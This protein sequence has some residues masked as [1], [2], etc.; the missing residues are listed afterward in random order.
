MGAAAANPQAQ[1]RL[2]RQESSATAALTGSLHDPDGRPVVGANIALTER[3]TGRMSAT[4]NSGDGVFRLLEVAP[5]TYDL[6]VTAAGYETIERAALELEPDKTVTLELV[7]RPIIIA[8]DLTS[9][10]PRAPELGPPSASVEETPGTPYSTIQPRAGTLPVLGEP[11]T[12]PSASQ[13]FLETPERWSISIPEWNRYARSGEY[14]YVRP[15]WWD[16]FNRNK[17]KG[18]VPILGQQTFLNFTGTSV[19]Q[20]DGRRLPLPSGVSTANPGSPGFFGKGEQLFLG[21]TFRFSFDLFHGDTSFRPVDW[22]IRV[23]PTVNVNYLKVRELGIVN[24]DVRHGTTR[25]DSRI[26]LQEA[27]VEVKLRDLS[28]NYDFVSVRAGIQQFKRDF[29]G[30]LFVEEQPGIRIFG[31]L[32]SNRW[33]YNAAYFYFLEKDTNSGLNTFEPRHQQVFLVNAYHQDFL[34]PGYTAQLSVHYNKDDASLHYD[35]ND[36]LVR[37]API[38]SVAPHNIRAAYIGW[39]GDGHFGRLNLTHAF[40]QALGSDSLNPIAGRAVTIN[41]QMA[42]AEV[43]VD[44]DWKRFKASVFYASGDASPRDNRARGFD[45]I[46]DSPEFAGGIFSLWN[47]EGIRLTGTGVALT[48]PDSLLPSLRSNKEEGQANFVNPGIFLVNAGANF[49]LTPKL[50]SL[51]NV[52]FLR[53]METAPLEELLFQAPIH[54]TIGMEY[55]VGAEYRPPLSENIVIRGGASALTPGQGLRDIY[56]GKTQFS[57]FANVRLQF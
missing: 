26:G 24:P 25:L 39:T 35:E 36:F 32:R 45:A 54:S 40:Y 23:T 37:P 33:Q 8:P 47:R 16:P 44:R 30:F 42:A 46:V 51:V 10:I 18:D 17:L 50:R 20:L 56:S 15:H 5:G 43:S 41:A 7:L 22:R 53:F 29:R 19:T 31:T 3:G 14:P 55:N 28:A 27:Q 34:R 21:Q 9:R 6:R 48:P 12:L 4:T 13:V 57:V 52:N 1:Q 2:P 11:V 49:D 38:G